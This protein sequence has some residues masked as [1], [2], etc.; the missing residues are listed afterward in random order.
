MQ[1]ES[2]LLRVVVT[3]EFSLEEAKRNFQEV[4]GAV[5]QY[6]ATKVLLDGG[7]M[8]GNPEAV[9]RFYYGD[10]A[11]KETMRLLKEHGIFP[12]FACVIHEPLRDPRKFGETVA[13]NRG[14]NIKVC[15]TPE[16]AFA[17]L[18]LTLP[19]NSGAGDAL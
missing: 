19:N 4:L 11:A 5:V 12:R 14:M 15:E 13:V 7:T 18:E 16:E 1:F 3:G 6:R 9:E 8:K 17:W 2:G 10:F